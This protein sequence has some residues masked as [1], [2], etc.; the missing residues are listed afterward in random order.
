MVTED[1]MLRKIINESSEPVA[2]RLGIENMHSEGISY[3][4]QGGEVEMCRNWGGWG[5]L[6]VEGPG[7]NN[8]DRS[9]DP[10][11]RA[12]IVARMAALKRTTAPTPSGGNRFGSEERERGMQTKW[13]RQLGASLG[14]HLLIGRP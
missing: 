4:P 7:Q 14:R 6:S 8:P 3:K 5:Q 9:E 10:W 12:T 13:A 11:G 1:D 2:G